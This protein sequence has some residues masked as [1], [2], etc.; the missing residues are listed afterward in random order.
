MKAKVSLGEAAPDCNRPGSSTENNPP[1]VAIM[2]HC[3]LAQQEA[4]SFEGEIPRLRLE[5]ATFVSVST[6]PWP[7]LIC[8]SAHICVI[9]PCAM[10]AARSVDVSEPLRYPR[11][12]ANLILENLPPSHDLAWFRS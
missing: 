11:K 7:S 5:A 2:Q 8:V 10:S 3:K 1:A 4:R 6:S 12:K 9:P